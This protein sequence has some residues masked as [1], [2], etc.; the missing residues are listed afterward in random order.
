[1]KKILSLLSL[2]ALAHTVMGQS[3]WDNGK[4]TVSENGRYLQHAN[5]KPFFW[6]VDTC[7]LL[8]QKLDRDQIN[9]YF[10]DRKAKGFNVVQTIVFQLINDKNVY[11]DSAIL[12]GD[13]TKLN[14]TPGNNPANPAEYDYWDHVDFA[15]DSAAAHSIYLAMAPTWSHTVRRAPVTKEQA[16]AYVTVVAERFKNKPNVVWLNGGSARGNENADVWEVI[17]ATIKKIAPDQLMTFHPFGRSQSSTWFQNTA[18]LDFNAFTSGHRRYDQ[19]IEGKKFGEDNWRYV[20]EDLAKSPR[21]PTL[22]AE[23]SYENTPQGLHDQSQPYWGAA[24]ARRYAYWAV[25]AGAAGHTYGENSVRQVYLPSEAR[26]ASGAKGYFTE[27]LNAEGAGQMQHLKHLILSRPYF[28]RVNDQSIVAGHEG[29]KYDRVLVTRGDGFVM[30]YVHTG[31]TFKLNLGGIEAP[32]LKAWW[33]N[34]RTGTTA[35]AGQHRNSG[36]VTFVPPGEAAPGNDWVL[37][38]NDVSR[39]FNPPAAR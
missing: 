12:D 17:G 26:P 6:L 36:T 13:F 38:L 20:L 11:G 22:D 14:I 24:D 33:F 4:L 3:P 10:A 30:G 37:V 18:W 8:V 9:A 34:P 31:R 5:G 19:D 2:L 23:P 28:S 7:W 32:E 35:A 1:M 39:T 27:R 15:I 29:E 16:E 21:E 25:F